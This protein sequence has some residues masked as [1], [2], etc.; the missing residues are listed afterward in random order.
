MEKI[1]LVPVQWDP[2][3]VTTFIL[4]R[5][6]QHNKID[7]IIETIHNP[8]LDSFQQHFTWIWTFET[9]CS[10]QLPFTLICAGH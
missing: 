10:P 7:N 2:S 1:I 9:Q 4:H 8:T 3:C 5:P 6:K